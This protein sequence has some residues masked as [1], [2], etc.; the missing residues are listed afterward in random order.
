MKKEKEKLR[1]GKGKRKKREERAEEKEEKNKQKWQKRRKERLFIPLLNAPP[2]FLATPGNPRSSPSRPE[3][4]RR[5]VSASAP[6]APL[7][8]KA[9]VPLVKAAKEN[10]IPL[11]GFCI[12]DELTFRQ[13]IVYVLCIYLLLVGFSRRRKYVRWYSFQWLLL[14]LKIWIYVVYTWMSLYDLMTVN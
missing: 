3:E 7:G 10:P 5:G 12:G 11:W 2:S 6:T 14:P 9:K 1:R 13:F 8:W 4:I